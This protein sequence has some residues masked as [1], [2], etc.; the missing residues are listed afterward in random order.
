MSKEEKREIMQRAAEGE[1][2]LKITIKSDSSMCA[3]KKRLRLLQKL[4]RNRFFD[5]IKGADIVIR[6]VKASGKWEEDANRVVHILPKGRLAA[7]GISLRRVA[8]HL[9]SVE[10]VFA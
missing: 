7:D 2:P 5:F 9:E 4:E 3:V 6:A 10:A 8:S 1:S